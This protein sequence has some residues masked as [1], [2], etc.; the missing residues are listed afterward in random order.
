V[1]FEGEC[2]FSPGAAAPAH[3]ASLVPVGGQIGQVSRELMVTARLVQKAV[4]AMTNELTRCSAIGSDHRKTAK[5]RLDCHTSEALE[6]RTYHRCV[7]TAHVHGGVCHVTGEANAA[8]DTLLADDAAQ[9]L[10]E[11][12]VARA[13]NDELGFDAAPTQFGD[14]P[15]R[16]VL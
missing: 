3:F 4:D 6:T 13:D 9:A 12:W 1:T 7:R 8:F 14:R 11:P 16:L 10:L 2:L 15:N 5:H